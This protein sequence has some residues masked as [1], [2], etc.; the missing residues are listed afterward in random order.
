MKQ[1]NRPTPVKCDLSGTGRCAAFNLRKTALALTML[2]DSV[3]EASGI[4]STQF[5]ILIAVAKTQPVSIGRLSE[6]LLIDRTTLTRS[7]KLMQKEGLLEIS[8]R[9]AMRQRFVT[10]TA[11]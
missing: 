8:Q 9:L 5:A 10:L 1:Q 6:L 2:Y 3:L 7:L 11:K 4:R